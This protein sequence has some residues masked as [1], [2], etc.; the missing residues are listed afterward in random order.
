MKKQEGTRDSGYPCVESFKLSKD[1][2]DALLSLVARGDIGSTKSEVIR[3]L[4]RRS[5]GYLE[6]EKAINFEHSKVRTRKKAPPPKNAVSEV[7]SAIQCDFARMNSLLDRVATNLEMGCRSENKLD[8]EF[9][10]FLLSLIKEEF[11]FLRIDYTN[12]I[13]NNRQI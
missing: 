8:L 12:R 7:F 11:Y 3:H 5:S 10:A 6:T 4:I 9:L 13:E 2:A 1:D